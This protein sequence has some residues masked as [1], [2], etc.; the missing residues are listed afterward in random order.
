MFSL[1]TVAVIPAVDYYLWAKVTI[2]YSF[3]FF[4]PEH[5]L[6]GYFDS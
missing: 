3:I 5:D 1:L 4:H 2:K 6:N